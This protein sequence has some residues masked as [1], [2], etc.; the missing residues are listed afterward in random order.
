MGSKR[1]PYQ[2]KVCKT[3]K[4]VLD[5]AARIIENGRWTQFTYAKAV[6]GVMCF[7]AVGAIDVAAGNR[8]PDTGTRHYK[9]SDVGLVAI[10]EVDRLTPWG[11]VNFNDK[12]TTAAPVAA[13]LREVA[14]QL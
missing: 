2:P 1:R 4:G 3:V 6:D 12:Q 11:I 8:D 5:E 14:A 10:T 13:R 9:L 7:C